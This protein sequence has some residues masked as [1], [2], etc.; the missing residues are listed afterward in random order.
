MKRIENNLVDRWY[1]TIEDTDKFLDFGEH[2]DINCFR[3]VDG[4]REILFENGNTYTVDR[5]M[6]E[7]DGDKEREIIERL[8]ECGVEFGGDSE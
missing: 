5:V 4:V 7:T 3:Q 8:A 6:R 1:A 2:V